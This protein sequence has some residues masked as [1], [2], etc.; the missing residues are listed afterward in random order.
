MQDARGVCACVSVCTPA[1]AGIHLTDIPWLGLLTS[2]PLGF[3]VG[4]VCLV[5]VFQDRVSPCSPSCLGIHSVDLAVLEVTEL[6][7]PQ[8]P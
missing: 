2:T 8:P 1:C 5:L 7:Q 6:C 4:T 3:V